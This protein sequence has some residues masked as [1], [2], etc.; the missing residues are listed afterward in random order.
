VRR[1]LAAN[2]KAS[3][4]IAK[5]EANLMLKFRHCLA[6]IAAISMQMSAAAQNPAVRITPFEAPSSQG[7]V[8]GEIHHHDGTEPKNIV[9]V[10]GGSGVGDRGDTAAAIGLF[11]SPDTAVVIYDR[12]GFGASSGEATRPG[13][14]NSTWLVPALANDVVDIARH[15]NA[16]GYQRIGLMGSSM[17]GWINVAATA[18]TDC[19]DFAINIVGGAVPVL[20]SDTYDGLTDQGIEQTEA[21]ERAR[22]AGASIGY[23]PA[24]DLAS[25]SIPMLWVLAARDDSNPSMLDI[26]QIEHFQ[27]SGKDYDY[28]LVANVGHEFLDVD[29]GQPVL[30]WVSDVQTF[31]DVATR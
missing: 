19:V 16:L 6:A 31:V 4:I 21:L 7:L 28:I 2:R 11:L 5:K 12:R 8:A 13:T 20:V 3:A 26:E 22:D 29:T 25:A 27:M 24:P 15:L 10:T 30:G 9:I 17:G 14:E 23:D 18:E 1:R